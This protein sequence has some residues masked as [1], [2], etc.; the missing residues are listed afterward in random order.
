M[1]IASCLYGEGLRDDLEAA[2]RQGL[3]LQGFKLRLVVKPREISNQ[4]TSQPKMPE[5][6]QAFLPDISGNFYLR[7]KARDSLS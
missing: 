7:Q 3:L 4:L 1:L 5:T 6:A 2:G